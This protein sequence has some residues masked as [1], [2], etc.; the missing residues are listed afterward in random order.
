MDT[1]LVIIVIKTYYY[2]DNSDFYS[3][4][5]SESYK[6]RS[7]LIIFNDNYY[8]N[9]FYTDNGDFYSLNYFDSYKNRSKLV[10]FINYYYQNLLLQR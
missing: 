4:N 9:W 8:Y 6:N 2:T 7:K 5:Y 10:I 3:L 1:K